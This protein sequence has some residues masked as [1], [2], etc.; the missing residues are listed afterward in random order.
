MVKV[1]VVQI[2]DAI[3]QLVG[4]AR[5]L[6][7]RA[8]LISDL[9]IEGLGRKHGYDDRTSRMF[10]SSTYELLLLK[11]SRG[12]WTSRFVPRFVYSSKYNIKA[13]ASFSNSSDQLR[14]DL[15]QR[16]PQIVFLARLRSE[17]TG[18][19]GRRMKP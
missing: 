17:P 3:L 2:Q 1:I 15:E 7:Q 8:Y 14:L 12:F 10:A 6:D 19:G 5:S 9:R 18:G 11:I 13:S 4:D 16:A